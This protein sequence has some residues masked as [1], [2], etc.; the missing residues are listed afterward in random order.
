M[1][2]PQACGPVIA[3]AIWNGR[4]IGGSE[5]WGLCQQ[6][7]RSFPEFSAN[8]G[9]HR[10]HAI[11]NCDPDGVRNAYPRMNQ[12]FF[13]DEG[14][15]PHYSSQPA[16]GNGYLTCG[17]PSFSYS[18][19]VG[20]SRWYYA[21]IRYLRLI[22]LATDVGLNFEFPDWAAEYSYSENL[23]SKH[24]GSFY[25]IILCEVPI[26]EFLYSGTYNN[27]PAVHKEPQL[28]EL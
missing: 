27:A 1:S 26:D 21:H 15:R 2:T 6:D 18:Q 4:G 23:S 25:G 7:K 13:P 16:I 3:G 11:L 20:S 24:D 28:S 19:K 5:V 12:I 17:F 14:F 8:N 10:V 9:I 22:G